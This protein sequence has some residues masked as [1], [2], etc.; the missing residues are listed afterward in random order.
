MLS[1]D[2]QK[3]L[4][5]IIQGILIEGQ[6]DHLAA[7][8]N[9]LLGSFSTSTKVE[10]NFEQQ[11]AIKKKQAEYLTQFIEER[12]LWMNDVLNEKN[13]LTEG[14]EAK[15]YMTADNRTVV[16]LNDAIY[17]N[18]WL[19]FLNSVAIHNILFEETAYR[20]EGFILKND[21]LFAVLS[22]PFIISDGQTDLSD[23]KYYL[24]YNGFVNTRRNDY[25]NKEL[26]L[27][28]EDMHDEN[29]L[30]NSNKLF[31]IDTVFYIHLP[32]TNTQAAIHQ[33]N[34]YNFFTKWCAANKKP[35]FKYSLWASLRV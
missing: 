18:T 25:Y 1:N 31:F 15:I 4:A 17:Y 3:R 21:C 9:F 11:S 33:K 8:R 6:K 29:V 24:E 5:D 35:L 14:G 13:Y 12:S 23:V 34:H 27:I 22:Q 10:K 2:T 32:W 16:K 20:L 19:D 30:V 28:L 7:A 26:G